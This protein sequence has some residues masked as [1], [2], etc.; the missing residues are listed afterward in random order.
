ME[1]PAK[2]NILLV[3]DRSENLVALEAILEDLDRNLIK[4]NSGKEALSWLLKE[5]FA[6]ILLDVKMPEMNGFET[7][8]LIRQ[9]ERTRN[10]PII[11]MTAFSKTDNYIFKGYSL[12]AV[13][14][15]LKP[16]EPHILISK[17]RVFVDL[18]KKNIELKD[19]ES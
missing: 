4:A 14:Y 5:D 10:I 15:L 6:L 7:A 17:V 12:G 19:R 9:R 16:I 8:S 2:V 1:S 18:F 13:D 11:F 3:D